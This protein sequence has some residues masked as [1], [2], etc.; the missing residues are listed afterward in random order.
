M[1]VEKETEEK[2][3]EAARRVFQKHGYNGARMQEIADE[4]QINKAMLHYYYRSKEKLFQAVFRSAI[5]KLLPNLFGILSK[6]QSL[7]ETIVEL[8]DFYHDLFRDD[9]DLPAFVVFEMNNNP[10]QFAEFMGSQSLKLPETFIA[11]VKEAV[12]RGE[13]RPV[14]PEHL[15]MNVVGMS[16]MPVVAK[17]M[18]RFL[19]TFDDERYASFLEERR[20]L[21]PE[22][23]FNGIHSAGEES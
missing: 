17:N 23:V 6:P 13:I 11:K 4:A 21:I 1:A 5:Q 18:V 20:A 16:M 22:M 7:H 8:V 14:R 9:P 19:F 3:F 10:A 12:S 2:I 15:L